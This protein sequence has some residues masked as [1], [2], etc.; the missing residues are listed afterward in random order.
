MQVDRLAADAA[1]A[2]LVAAEAATITGENELKWR[3]LRP[4]PD[5]FDWAP[6]DRLFAFASSHRLL[7]RGHTLVWHE[8]G[9]D[10]LAGA[11]RDGGLAGATDRH[12]ETVV[13]RCA[14]RVPWWDVVNEPIRVEDGAPDGLRRTIFLERLGPSYIEHALRRARAADPGAVLVINEMDLEC[15]GSHFDRRR[16]AFLALVRR[17][18]D[19]G[20]PLGAVGIES[21]LKWRQGTF[22]PALFGDYLGSLA[23]LGLAIHLTE[24]D[25]GDARLPAAFEPRDRAVADLASRYLATALAEPSV[26]IVNVWGLS[27][28]YSWLSSSPWTRRDDGLPVRGCA[29]DDVLRPKRMRGAIEAALRAAPPR[30]GDAAV[31]RVSAARAT[32]END[33]SAVAMS[34]VR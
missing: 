14:G 11:A 28:R 12:I 19:A 33:S 9:P 22:D 5:R 20:A 6:A 3:R 17:L 8:D 27:D 30:A 25:I 13:G 23:S 34:S 29:Y 15:V 21:H 4:A 18:L 2:A 32:S 24:F 1:Y 16:A 10:W 31:S 7:V 26:E